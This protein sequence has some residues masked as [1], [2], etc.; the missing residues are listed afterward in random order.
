MIIVDEYA[1]PRIYQWRTS[2]AL[3]LKQREARPRVM[4]NGE[5]TKRMLDY[6]VIQ[7][8]EEFFNIQWFRQVSEGTCLC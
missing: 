7:D 4:A 8:I 2:S 5:L 3:R 6:G 1:G